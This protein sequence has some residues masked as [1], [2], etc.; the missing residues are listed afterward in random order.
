MGFS[1]VVLSNYSL[2]AV[3]G[4]LLLQTMGP[5]EFQYVWLPGSRAKAQ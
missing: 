2:V 3:H 5:R 4:L 1:L